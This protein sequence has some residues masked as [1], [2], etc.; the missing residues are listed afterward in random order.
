[1]RTYHKI[2]SV[3]KR[4]PENRFKTLLMGEFSLPEFAY[5]Q[6]NHWE[7]TEKVDG[8]NIRVHY[9]NGELQFGGRTEKA[10]IPPFL[11]E[12]L[13]AQFVPLLP[14][15]AERFGDKEVLLFGEGYGNRIQKVGKLY[16]PDQGFV[17]FDVLIGH[18][19]FLRPDVEQVAQDLGLDVVPLMGQGTL[20][21]MV[22]LTRKGFTSQWG[23]FTAEGIVARPNE[24]LLARNG[25]R[26][27]TKLK[28]RDFG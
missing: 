17:L 5:L 18:F 7:F 1:M 6:H 21:E 27:I 8:T 12:A 25:D 19:W 24:G 4:D 13:K 20:H 11:L 3:F 10:D 23:A 15:L 9:H 14:T 28:H 2:Q 22:E 26:I 16:R